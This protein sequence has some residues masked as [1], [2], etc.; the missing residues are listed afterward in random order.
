MILSKQGMLSELKSV[1][2]TL[3]QLAKELVRRLGGRRGEG[4][5]TGRSLRIASA[6]VLHTSYE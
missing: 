6:L 3:V 5:R 2:F 4:Y 1:K